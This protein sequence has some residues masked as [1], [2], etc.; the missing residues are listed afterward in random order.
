MKLIFK[1][2]LVLLISFPALPQPEEPGSSQAGRFTVQLSRLSRNFTCTV[3]YPAISSGQNTPPD[4]SQGKFPVIAFGHG[5]FMQTS[6]YTSIFNHLASHGFIVIAPQFFDTQHG[7]LARD[8]LTCINYIKSLNNDSNSPLFGLI[9]TSSIGVSGHS[10]G[11]GASLLATVY[12]SIITIAVPLA[13]AETTPSVINVINQSNSILYLISAQNDGITPPGTTQTP[14]YNNAV[15][16]KSILYL[17]GA[18]HTKFMDTNLFDWTDPN[19]YMTR[20]NQQRL[21][22]RYLTASFKHF[23]KKDTSYWTYLFGA[24]NQS[25]TSVILNFEAKSLPL[26]DFTLTASYDTLEINAN[27]QFNWQKPFTLNLNDIISYNLEIATSPDF[28][29]ILETYEGITDT[30]FSVDFVEFGIYY[31]RVKAIASDTSITSYS[32]T[33]SIAVYI[34]VSVREKASIGIPQF[35]DNYPNP[36]KLSDNNK[37][38]FPYYFPEPLSFTVEVYGLEGTLIKSYP[39]QFAGEGFGYFYFDAKNN[40]GNLLPAGVYFVRILSGSSSVTKKILLVK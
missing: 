13:A 38:V 21:T 30:A 12:D 10:M 37:S 33:C 3:V 19:G 15:P 39:E 27:A 6:Y 4:T 7:E 35:F 16:F 5:F 14:M 29:E 11:G 24:E 40:S 28:L 2:F 31:I 32:N 22:R 18:N 34:P 25:D 1:L 20:L 17:K 8:M 36:V 9:D 26:S 23:L